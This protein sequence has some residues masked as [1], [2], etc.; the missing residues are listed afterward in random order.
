MR[1]I[2]QAHTTSVARVALAWLLHQAAV[3]AVIIG[4]R[5]NEQL[6]DNL[7]ASELKLSSADLD[8]LNKASALPPEYPGW[9]LERQ[10]ADR[11]AVIK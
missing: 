11:A 2:A 4:A 3:T 8:A 10:T 6:V 1:P 5:T 9:M 7:G